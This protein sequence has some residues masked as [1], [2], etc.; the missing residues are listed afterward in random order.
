M[1]TGTDANFLVGGD[2]SIHHIQF[3]DFI[4]LVPTA[5]KIID[6]NFM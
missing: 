6:I 3:Q 4:L 2:F 5:T 1:Y